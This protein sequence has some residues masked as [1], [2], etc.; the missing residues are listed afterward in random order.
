MLIVAVAR[1]SYDRK[2]ICYVLPVLRMTSRG[3]LQAVAAR[4]SGGARGRARLASGPG[5][6]LLSPIVLLFETD[7]HKAAGIALLLCCHQ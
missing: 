4:V 7:Q 2:V 3:W 5:A 6:K 1:S